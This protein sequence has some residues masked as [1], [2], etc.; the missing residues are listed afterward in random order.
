LEKKKMDI[1]FLR[2]ESEVL[3]LK[4]ELAKLQSGGGTPSA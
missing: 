4:V 2:E 1:E 3:R